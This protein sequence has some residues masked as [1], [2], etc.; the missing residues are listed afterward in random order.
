MAEHDYSS[1]RHD[2]MTSHEMYSPILAF[3]DRTEFDI[4]VCCTQHNIPARQH[5]TEKEDGLIQTWEGLC[6]LNPEFR[7]TGKW[8]GKSVAEV[9]INNCEV[10]AVLPM[11]RLYVNYYHDYILNNR[12]CVFGFL[13][14]KQ[15]FIIPGEEKEPIKP[16]VGIMIACFSNDAP[17][18]EYCWNMENLFGIRAFLGGDGR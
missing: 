12:A 14:G 16:S 2:Y 10:W 5:F 13:K 17:E 15:G 9:A 6:F 3:R 11:D 8:V 7:Y 1:Q 4:D 18:I